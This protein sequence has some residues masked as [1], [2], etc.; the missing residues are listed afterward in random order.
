MNLIK[1]Y[2]LLSLGITAIFSYGNA[3][4]MK[5]PAAVYCQEMGY[6][7]QNKKSPAGQ[8][9]ICVVNGVDYP[10]WDFFQGKVGKENSFCEKNG[11]DTI[12]KIDGKNS[13]SPDY[14]VCIPK[15]LEGKALQSQGTRTIQ[16]ETASAQEIPMYQLMGLENKLQDES[17]K[18]P[19]QEFPP[20][21]FQAPSTV[22]KNSSTRAPLDS[23][24]L[25]TEFSWTNKDGKNWMTP[26][27]SQGQYNL[28]Q[29]FSSIG[30]MEAKE[31]IVAEDATMNPDLAEQE[32]P[33]KGVLNYTSGGYP[34]T[35]L[36]YIKNIGIV[37]ESVLPFVGSTSSCQIPTN[38]KKHFITSWNG[39][40]EIWKDPIENRG[41]IKQALIEKGPLI[42]E[43]YMGG[44]FD[45]N[46]IYKCNSSN[47][48][49]H[50]IA[51]VGYKDTGDLATSYYVA[52]NSWGTG[53]NGN[54]YFKIGWDW[55]LPEY[56][57]YDQCKI[58]FFPPLF[59]ET[60]K[61]NYIANAIK[62]LQVLSGKQVDSPMEADCTKNGKVGIEDVVCSLQKAAELR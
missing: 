16:S 25:P 9:D 12:T 53:W 15:N 2:S 10:A 31:K 7:Y 46:G 39:I 8:T 32:I 60:P 24:T 35:V 61:P 14:A 29:T 43:I 51:I 17:I 21:L 62:G 45:G 33:C 27:K 55:N 22:Q 34:E 5:N 37:E 58:T 13:F 50:S 49:N 19:V 47:S 4:A 3:L 56:G 52:K 57:V 1:K 48:R 40:S 20:Q 23:P 18:E 38:A 41:M 11:Y 42:A 30:A 6:E 26:V 28:C 54:G 36:L 44:N 59:V